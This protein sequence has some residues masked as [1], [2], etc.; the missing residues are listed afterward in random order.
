MALVRTGQ[1][2][3]G[4]SFDRSRLDSLTLGLDRHASR[5]LHKLPVAITRLRQ[6]ASGDRAVLP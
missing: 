5:N 1:R 6:A 4:K 2:S 3:F